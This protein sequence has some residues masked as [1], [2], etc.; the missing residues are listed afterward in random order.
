MVKNSQLNIKNAITSADFMEPDDVLRTKQALESLGYY[1]VPGGVKTAYPDG[2]MFE[3][4]HRFQKDHRLRADGIVR[5]G[6]ATQA[7]INHCLAGAAKEAVETPCA[8]HRAPASRQRT[9]NR[10]WREERA[11]AR[12]RLGDYCSLACGKRQKVGELKKNLRSALNPRIRE[13]ITATMI[14]ISEEINQIESL[15]I[16]ID[17]EI[18]RLENSAAIE[19]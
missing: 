2:P 3:G 13:E 12:L 7:A 4:I 10:H 19:P 9:A 8:R 11:K 1:G 16:E 17:M 15:I 14:G 6:G 18:Q 5:P